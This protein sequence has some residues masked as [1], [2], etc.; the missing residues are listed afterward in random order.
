MHLPG[1]LSK[2]TCTRGS[3][4]WQFAAHQ[5]ILLQESAVFLVISAAFRTMLF[6]S[7]A[8][9][10]TI[11]RPMTDHAYHS[12]SC[13]QQSATHRQ[14][15]A[16]VVATASHHDDCAHVFGEKGHIGESALLRSFLAQ[17]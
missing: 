7:Y 6:S 17:S 5:R 8:E 15:H 9:I 2:S 14:K 12:Q 16:N 3:V 11:V 10:Q 1:H 4:P 13:A